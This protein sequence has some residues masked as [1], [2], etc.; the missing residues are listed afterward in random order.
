MMTCAECGQPGACVCESVDE[1]GSPSGA[2]FHV[3]CYV[4]RFSG[5]G[6]SE[7]E[8]LRKRI[9]G[10][11]GGVGSGAGKGGASWVRKLRI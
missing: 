10:A 3:T 9:R 6:T 2:F 8:R 1:S 11:R 5:D 4:K 7:A